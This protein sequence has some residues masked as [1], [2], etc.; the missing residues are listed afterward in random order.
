[1]KDSHRLSFFKKPLALGIAAALSVSTL[2]NVHAANF[3]LGDFDIT[4]DS[5]FSLGTSIRVEDRNWDDNIGKANNVNNGF[6]FSTY[7]PSFNVQPS[8]AELWDGEGIYSTNGDNGNLNFDAG[9][10]FSTI[11]KGSHDIDIRYDNMGFFTRALYFYDF[12]MA[13]GDRAWDDPLTGKNDDPC[14]DST[15]SEQ[16][17]KDF[18]ILDAFFYADFDLGEMPLSIRLGQQVINWGEST[19]IAH[20]ISELN[21]VDISRLRAPGAELKEAFIPIGALWASLGVT[22]NFNVELFYQYD[23][24]KTVIPAPGSYF[25]TNDFAGDG[26]YYNN[27]QLN[28][29]AN[30][31]MDLDFLLAGLNG[32]GDMLRSGNPP[33][34]CSSTSGLFRL[35]YK[36]NASSA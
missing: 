12:E 18:R 1:M 10:A 16:L 4:F 25:S 33:A 15:A 23:W 8:G 30:P 7:H 22:E 14:R 13:D 17:C 31:D 34:N 5:T 32:L 26:G 35:R 3:Q 29:S 9:D 21:P 11:I 20:G 2:S 36:I 28:F 19:L 6:D 27:V 24:E